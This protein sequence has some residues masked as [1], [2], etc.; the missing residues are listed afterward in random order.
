MSAARE[1][2]GVAAAPDYKG[3]RLTS[4]K[5]D[6]GQDL[7]MIQWTADGRSI[8]YVRGGNLEQIGQAIPNALSQAQMPDQSIWIVPFEGGAPK[9]LA[10]GHSPAPAKDGHVAFL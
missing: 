9:R 10:E 1:T 4:Y 8:V 2:C 7:G 3:C 5:G 6:D